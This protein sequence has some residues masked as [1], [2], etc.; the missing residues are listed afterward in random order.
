MDVPTVKGGDYDAVRAKDGT[1]T[2]LDVPI[3]ADCTRSFKLPNGKTIDAKFDR[4]WQE[5]AVRR[6]K[7]KHA[8]SGVMRSIYPRHKHDPKDDRDTLGFFLPKD[9]R[10]VEL[11]GGK[12]A[13][14]FADYVG[15]PDSVYAELKSRKHPYKSVELPIGADPEFTGL[16]WLK[17]PPFHDDFALQTVGK[18][19]SESPASEGVI[20]FA[21]DA[22]LVAHALVRFSM[23]DPIKPEDKKEEPVATPAAVPPVGAVEGAPAAPVADASVAAPAAAPVDPASDAAAKDAESDKTTMTMLSAV[24]AQM[25][26]LTD[27]VKRIV[28]G[29]QT[30]GSGAPRPPAVQA[31]FDA[32]GTPTAEFAAVTAENAALKAKVDAFEKAESKRVAVAKAVEALNG[33]A[34]GGDTAALVT[35]KFDAGGT[36]AVDGFVAGVT[37]VG[38][39]D[40]DAAWAKDAGAKPV[41]SL[42]KKFPNDPEL[43]A[44]FGA[45]FD[46]IPD[47]ARGAMSR[48]RYVELSMGRLKTETK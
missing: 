33:Y 27:M 37:L 8:A 38:K 44:Q 5:A 7:D 34:L 39:K 6:A 16:A 30:D 1:W 18:E 46:L 40:P 4:A 9:V 43:V 22:G 35:A 23:P 20:G 45:E 10:D 24:M 19:I 26:V 36:V 32:S 42:A 29:V 2:I 28:G 14:T 21:S 3:F 12:R 31:A 25:S 48:E 17:E 15:V 11:R 47:V 41:D 13:V